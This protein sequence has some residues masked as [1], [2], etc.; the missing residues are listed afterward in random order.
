MIE[1]YDVVGGAV[2]LAQVGALVL[3]LLTVFA[4]VVFVALVLVPAFIWYEFERTPSDL[5]CQ[6]EIAK[7]VQALRS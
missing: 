4:L 6:T 1:T 5:D 3:G 7:I 2:T